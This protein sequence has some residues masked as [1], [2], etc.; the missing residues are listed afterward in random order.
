MG[1]KKEPGLDLTMKDLEP[2]PERDEMEKNR[3]EYHFVDFLDCV[4]SRNRENLNAEVEGGHMSTSIMLL[5]NIA[6]K[7]G[8]K[9]TFDG[10]TENFVNDK[11]A[12]TYLSRQVERKPYILPKVA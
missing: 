3:I 9:L 11:E 10:K 4:R 8:R 5:G 2:E 1:P 6:Y 7:T 12:N